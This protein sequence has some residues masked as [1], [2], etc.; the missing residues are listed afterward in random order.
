M[1]KKVLWTTSYEDTIE[2]IS[3]ICG[4]SEE[5]I[6]NYLKYSVPFN[7]IIVEDIKLSKFFKTIGVK[8]NCNNDL[9]EI[10]KF[11]RCV[12]SHLTTRTTLPNE[13][14]IY[15]LARALTKTTDISKFLASKGITFKEMAQGLI[16]YHTTEIVDWNSFD[17]SYTYRIKK[18][19]KVRG[20]Y[21]D[22]CING[23]LFNHLFWEDSNV[24]H[25]KDCPE[26]VSDICYV[27]NRQDIVNE[28]RKISTSYALGFLVDIKDII[29]DE[30]TKFKTIKSKIYLTYKYVIYYLVQVYHDVWN[31]RFN[32]PIMRLKDNKSVSKENIVGFYKI[33]A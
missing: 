9:F 24:E 6:N 32:N 28:W 17:S 12:I 22:N 33:E 4:C 29:F 5:S 8:F 19:L 23:F 18:R 25:I 7:N 16:T 10:I 14:D 27:L 21:I 13:S 11:D 20:K 1:D 15:C 3:Y 30:H 31:T 26:I 2:S